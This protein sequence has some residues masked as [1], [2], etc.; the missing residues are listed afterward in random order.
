MLQNRPTGRTLWQDWAAFHDAVEEL[1]KDE[2]E[3]FTLIWY[4]G[5][6]RKDVATLLGIA[7]KTVMRRFNRARLRLQE[8]LGSDGL[9]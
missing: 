2:Q 8:T 1:P 3:V 5:L 4:G 6:L 7:D 9:I